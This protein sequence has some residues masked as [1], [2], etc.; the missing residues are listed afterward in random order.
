MITLNK[1]KLGVTILSV[2]VLVSAAALGGL[3]MNWHSERTDVTSTALIVITSDALTSVE[4]EPGTYLNSSMSINN[5]GDNIVSMQVST[6]ITPDED[7][8][9]V[10]YEYNGTS[11]NENEP[12]DV[13]P[14]SNHTL[15]VSTLS[16]QKLIPAQYVITT[17]LT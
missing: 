14:N 1:Q 17:N 11:I 2:F 4:I 9:N 15:N 16:D 10:Q 7:G 13:L 8:F 6:N 5:T 3:M 12:F